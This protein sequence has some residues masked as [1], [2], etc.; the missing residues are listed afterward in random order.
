MP[1]TDADGVAG[2]ATIGELTDF[3]RR[4][5]LDADGKCGSQTWAALDRVIYNL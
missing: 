2:N 3:Q 5:G 1:G 4:H